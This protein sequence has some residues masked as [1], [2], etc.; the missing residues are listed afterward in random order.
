[1]SPS[2]LLALLLSEPGVWI[3]VPRPIIAV[4]VESPVVH[5]KY[6][7]TSDVV[8][9][10]AG[11]VSGRRLLVR[12]IEAGEI[13]ACKVSV[14][15]RLNRAAAMRASHMLLL[16]LQ[17]DADSARLDLELYDVLAGM[18]AAGAGKSEAEVEDAARLKLSEEAAL[19]VRHGRVDHRELGAGAVARRNASAEL[20]GIGPVIA[21]L[22]R[23][24]GQHSLVDHAAAVSERRGPSAGNRQAAEHSR[25]AGS[26]GDH[27]VVW[28]GAAAVDVDSVRELRPLDRHFGGDKR[29]RVRV[30][31]D[32]LTG[33]GELDGVSAGHGL[34][35]GNGFTKREDAVVGVHSVS[36]ACDGD[37]RGGGGV[38]EKHKRQ[39]RRQTPSRCREQMPRH[40]T[41]S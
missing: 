35:L 39:K 5:Q 33:D 26:D 2:V 14:L 25:A 10:L 23:I 4:S 27:S 40:V 22:A 38:T 17:N 31:E 11:A 15:C 19:V 30:D 24:D 41:G 20:A 6:L 9:A 21:D 37:R 12:P 3:P 7:A 13:E 18:R 1:M 32:D 8:A 36:E 28:G 34:G 16:Y 29:K